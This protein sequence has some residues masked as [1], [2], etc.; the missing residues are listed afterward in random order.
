M[1]KGIVIYEFQYIYDA[2]TG[3]RQKTL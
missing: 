2:F 3:M 1:G